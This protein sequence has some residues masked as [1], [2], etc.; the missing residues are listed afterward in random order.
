MPRWW[1]GNFSM[2]GRF[3]DSAILSCLVFG[4][5]VRVLSGDWQ[6]S[7]RWIN[8]FQRSRDGGGRLLAL[9]RFMA[10]HPLR[11]VGQQRPRKMS[12]Y[13]RQA[14]FLKKL[15]MYEDTPE[16]RELCERLSQVERSERCT[17]CACRLV[18]L[19]ALLGLS[20]LGYAAVLLPQFF[21]NSTHFIV[22]LCSALGLGSGLCLTVFLGLWY[23]YRRAANRLHAQCR[24]SI[25]KMLAQKI[26]SAAI[27]SPV[28]RDQ[29]A[30]EVATIRSASLPQFDDH[31]L[32][33]AS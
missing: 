30:M 14:D 20:G 12:E 19:I 17:Q 33:K 32:R 2:F 15:V 5:G 21:D 7:K 27:A 22:R 16:T 9:I 8:R 11:S 26:P 29:P 1:V 31:E 4:S 28:I 18:G 23:S 3:Q 13:Q 6:P 10:Q 25:S 24:L